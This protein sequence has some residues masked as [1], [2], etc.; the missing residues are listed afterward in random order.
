MAVGIVPWQCQ[1]GMPLPLVLVPLYSPDELNPLKAGNYKYYL[2]NSLSI[3]SLLGETHTQNTVW[4]TL[5]LRRMCRNPQMRKKRSAPPGILCKKD[6]SKQN[7]SGN[8]AS[9]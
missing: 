5:G 6:K 2:G 4:E 9:I 8:Q 7:C 1:E 3:R